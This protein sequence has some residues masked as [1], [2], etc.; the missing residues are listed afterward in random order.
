[1]FRTCYT[2][3]SSVWMS[4]IGDAS[5]YTLDALLR[6]SLLQDTA[7]STSGSDKLQ[8]LTSDPLSA[9]TWCPHGHV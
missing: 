1:M 8:G 6:H 4:P 7:D 3:G 2:K 9:T 5:S